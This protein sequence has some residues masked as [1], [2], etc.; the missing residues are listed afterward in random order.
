MATPGALAGAEDKPLVTH[1]YTADPSAHVFEGR[2]YVYPSHDRETDI[3]F[4]DNG[5]QYDMVDYH[6]LSLPHPGG[7]V[8]DH[9]V[10]LNVSLLDSTF[11][12]CRTVIRGGH[13]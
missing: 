5:D 2:I 3:Q 9:G 12:L 7:P 4:N 13:T 6:V 10:A 8:T 1:I 11:E